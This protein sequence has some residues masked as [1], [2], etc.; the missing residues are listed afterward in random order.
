MSALSSTGTMQRHISITSPKLA[1]LK[2]TPFV[3]NTPGFFDTSLWQPYGVV[4]VII[5][6]NA[7]L[8]FFRKK[9]APAVAA[10]TTV[11]VKSS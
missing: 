3:L 1:M 5:P 11:G 4:A 9:V 8:V 7:L 10:G 2:V 6:W